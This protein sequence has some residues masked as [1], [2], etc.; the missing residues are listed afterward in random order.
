MPQQGSVPCVFACSE[1]RCR[2]CIII[3]PVGS[4]CRYRQPTCAF[5]FNEGASCE[6]KSSIYEVYSGVTSKRIAEEAAVRGG[7][8]QSGLRFIKF[9]WGC[10]WVYNEKKKKKSNLKTN[11]QY[12]WMW[13]E[14]NAS[15][16]GDQLIRRSVCTSCWPH[17]IRWR[18]PLQSSEECLQVARRAGTAA[19]EAFRSA[20]RKKIMD[21]FF[22]NLKLC[23]TGDRSWFILVFFVVFF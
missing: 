11:R 22:F 1:C 9:R 5:I 6:K 17:G 15:A 8:L 2:W 7:K 20:E 12:E 14:Y 19:W 10:L 4:D 23:P 16:E 3:V 18:T 13:H 21:F